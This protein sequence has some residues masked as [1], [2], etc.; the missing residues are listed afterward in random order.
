MLAAK[1]AAWEK[2]F[3]S[4]RKLD[5]CDVLHTHLDLVGFDVREKTK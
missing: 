5:K 1:L 3:R 2:S 4:T